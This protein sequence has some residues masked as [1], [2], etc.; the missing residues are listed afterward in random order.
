MSTK[1]RHLYRWGAV[2]ALS[3]PLLATG[4][5]LRMAEQ[6]AAAGVFD[7]ITPELTSDLAERLAAYDSLPS[8]T[9]GSLRTALERGA[10]EAFVNAA[11][12]Q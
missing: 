12:A 10:L 11:T 8:R 4:T 6:A 5:C 9:T 3:L 2:A 1:M 7:A